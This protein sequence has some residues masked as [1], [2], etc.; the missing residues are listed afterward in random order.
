[1]LKV[2]RQAIAQIGHPLLTDGCIGIGR[3]AALLLAQKGG[4]IA[5]N[6]LDQDKAA[7]VV[8]EIRSLGGEAESFP[9]NVLDEEFPQRLMDAVL[10]KWG[11][12]NSLINNAGES[13]VCW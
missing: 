7:E 6:D 2:T 13:D 8:A 12:I 9:G 3:S 11:R 5:V 4:K 1:M 10:Q